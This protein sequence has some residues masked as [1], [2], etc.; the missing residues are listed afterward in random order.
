MRGQLAVGRTPATRR[1]AATPTRSASVEAGPAQRILLWQR[2]AGNRAVTR[3]LTQRHDADL[4][5]RAVQ[6]DTRSHRE[7]PPVGAL[8]PAGTLS[9]A[10]WTTAYRAAAGNPSTKAY[11]PLFRD[12]ALTAGMDGLGTGFVPGTIPV[13]DGKT[14][15]PGLNMTLDRGSEPGH[16]GWVDRG[17]A[18]GVPFKLDK[19]KPPDLT[20][21]VILSPG[22]LSPDKGLSLR[23]VR[24]EMVHARH[25]QKVLDAVRAW[26]STPAR[27]R[28]GFDDWL[29]QQAGRTKNPMS[30]LDVALIGKG[31]RDGAADTEVLAYVEGFTNDFHRR[32]ATLAQAGP[33]F[34][35]LLGAVETTKL[36]TWKQADPAVQ[37]EAI[38]RLREYHPTLDV[39]HQR[40]WKQ[41]LDQ[42]LGRS[43]NDKPRKDF[44][45]RLAAFVV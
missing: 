27:G 14:A 26:Q 9:E 13:S 41:W 20:I 6:R 23:T 31:V 8:Q 4:A 40:L 12:I 37:A 32:P 29:R 18:F 3:L 11:Q 25:K 42:Q 33:S 30:A 36:F 15:R 10:Q 28:P 38:T 24:H 5:G 21:A 45:Q 39:D 34:A 44:L 7:N 2:Q 19:A 43:G 35:E 17:G 16:T 22:A 1:A